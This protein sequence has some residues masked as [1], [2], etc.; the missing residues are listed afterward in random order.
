[1]GKKRL[2][3]GGY[4]EDVGRDGKDRQEKAC[5]KELIGLENSEIFIVAGE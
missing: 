4:A 1:M 5:A 3:S 2:L